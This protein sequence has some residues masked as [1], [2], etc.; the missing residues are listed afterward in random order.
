MLF[1]FI[2]VSWCSKRFPYLS[3]PPVFQWGLHYSLV[4]CIVFGKS[5]CS[6]YFRPLCCLSFF[7][8]R[9]LLPLWYLQTVLN[10]IYVYL[11]TLFQLYSANWTR[12]NMMW[13]NLFFYGRTVVS[14]F[15]TISFNDS[16]GSYDLIYIFL[17]AMF[18]TND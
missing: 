15:T 2:Y 4:F 14:L 17:R 7:D 9:F 3:S 6:F 13:L 10:I 5:F 16:N 11:S 18:N 12:Y 8:L 1:V